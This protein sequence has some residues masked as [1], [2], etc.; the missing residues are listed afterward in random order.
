MERISVV[1]GASII[2][3]MEL[4]VNARS[5]AWEKEVGGCSNLLEG[6]IGKIQPIGHVLLTQSIFQE[7]YTSR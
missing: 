6:S 3:E 7:R 2:A 1:L 5:P 4:F